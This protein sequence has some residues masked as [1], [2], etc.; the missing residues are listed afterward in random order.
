MK[1]PGGKWH[2]NAGFR[3]ALGQSVHVSLLLQARFSGG[4]L[5]MCLLPS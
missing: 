3:P 5:Q 1:V 4:Q 2:A